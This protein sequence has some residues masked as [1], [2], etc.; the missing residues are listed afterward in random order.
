VAGLGGAARRLG[1][2]HALLLLHVAGDDVMQEEESLRVHRDED[3][4]LEL[5]DE[6][7][8]HGGAGVVRSRRSFPLDVVCLPGLDASHFVTA[9]LLLVVEYKLDY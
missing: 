8:D 3:V 9:G 2:E 6:G 5:G 1:E 7:A 4:V